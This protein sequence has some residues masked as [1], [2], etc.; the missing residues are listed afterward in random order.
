MFKNYLTVTLRNLLRHKAYSAI[1]IFSLAIGLAASAIIFNW[2]R[3][4]YSFDLHNENV[5]RIYRII[6]E[7]K[8]KEGDSTY[9][10]GTGGKLAPAFKEHIP[11]IE[12]VARLWLKRIWVQYGD[13]GFEQ[14][15]CLADSSLLRVFTIPLLA[16]DPNVALAQ[17]NGIVISRTMAAKFFGDADPLGATLDLQD[18]FY[19]TGQYQVTGIMEDTPKTAFHTFDCV[20][21]TLPIPPRPRLHWEETWGGRHIQSFVMLRPK[22]NIEAVSAKVRE[23]DNYLFPEDV[24]TQRETFHLQPLNRV[25]LHATTDFPNLHT[26]R[27][28]GAPYGNVKM[29]YFLLAAAV[30]TL[31]IAGVNFVNLTTARATRRAR[32]VGVRKAIG[33]PRLELI[34]Q[35][36][37]ESVVV[38]GFSGILSLG[39]IE[40]GV[41]I[42]TR[43][44]ELPPG[45][46]ETQNLPMMLLPTCVIVGLIAGSYP[47]FY[48]SSFDPVEVLK[49]SSPRMGTSRSKAHSALVFTQFSISI[50]LLIA[51]LTVTQQMR[52]I[53]DKNLGF[54]QEHIVLTDIFRRDPDRTLLNRYDTVK[55]ELLK[56]PDVLSAT[57]YQSRLGLGEHGPAG[58]MEWVLPEGFEE[59]FQ[60]GNLVIDEDFLQTMGTR[61]LMG[62]NLDRPEDT[63][64]GDYPPESGEQSI[65][66]LL[67]ESA[68]RRLGW[69]D[70]IGKTLKIHLKTWATVVGVVEDFHIGSL[71]EKIEPM[72]LVKEPKQYK[73]LMI[74]IR[75]QNI[76]RTMVFLNATWDRFVPERP[77]DFG[78][79]D[80]RINALY[81]SD[82]QFARLV[83]SFATLTLT[84]ACLGLVGLIAYTAE[85]RTKEIGIRKVLG[86]SEIS[87]M[88][89]LTK[90]FLILI[91]LASLLAYPVAYYTMNSWLQNFAYRIDPSPTHFIASTGATLIITLITI[92]YQALKAARA[93]PV[94]ALKCE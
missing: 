42:L 70:P 23:L 17:P 66:I 32:E 71:H 12:E 24:E 92:A 5:D 35:Y 80:D 93:N 79:L 2:V 22:A 47:A 45:I 90:D 36:L 82:L 61:L 67:N 83:G 91:A 88:N 14:V 77:S 20:F 84:I 52:F 19:F 74:R 10:S 3:Y 62:R 55:Q 69:G 60:M 63:F 9:R 38:S 27:I 81:A 78:F 51:T 68:A 8:N 6:T 85:M 31:L 58:P 89:L 53:I 73:G 4:E 72:F 40:I 49:G 25:H 50:L 28:A 64:D 33:A 39:L 41:R 76:E 54:D 44:F 29:I 16:G 57:G 30:L 86:A 94:D 11:E 75:G 46:T 65:A 26:V 56:H 21:S 37:L 59:R 18:S 7:I 48:L 13:Q 34:Q 43:F 15:A 87:I 1:S